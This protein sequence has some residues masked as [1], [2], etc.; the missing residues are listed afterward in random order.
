MNAVLQ[1][2]PVQFVLSSTLRAVILP[3]PNPCYTPTLARQP[4][5]AAVSI[6]GNVLNQYVSSN[7]VASSS[8]SSAA[9][10][11]DVALVSVA[12]IWGINIPI[13]KIGLDQ[14][15]PFVFNAVR[16]SVASLVLNAFAFHERWQKGPRTSVGFLPLLLYGGMASTVY[17][18]LFL[19]G[20]ERTT[21]GNVGLIV[22]T[23]PL[24]TALLARMFGGETLRLWAWMGLAIACLGTVVVALQ[25]GDLAV[26]GQHQLGNFFILAA[27]LLWAGA[28]V[29]GRSL[30]RSIT[31]LQLSASASLIAL[32]M[33]LLFAAGRYQEA[34]PSLSSSDLWFIILY[35]GG[36][37]TGLALPLWNYGVQHAG[38]A[39]SANIQNLIPLTA[40]VAAWISRGETATAAQLIGGGLI[41]A[42]LVIMRRARESASIQQKQPEEWSE[43]DK[44]PVT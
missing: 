22:T 16:L 5:V 13:M 26:G 40:I 31:P 4:T 25:K 29:Y 42:G 8:H 34:L 18:L 9:I 7:P 38:A 21:S 41:L 19:L 12:L 27:S 11:P 36:L 15:D 44:P 10:W 17:Q 43:T 14:I 33:H 20:V 3:G 35:S 28:T 23:V 39:H 24:W 30:L 2:T 1:R 6:P 37:S 32:P